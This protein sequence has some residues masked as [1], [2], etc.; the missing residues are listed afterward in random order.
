[1]AHDL[2]AEDPMLALPRH[3]GLRERALHRYPR[4]VEL[5]RTG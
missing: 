4:A 3:L 5:F 2:L 1:V